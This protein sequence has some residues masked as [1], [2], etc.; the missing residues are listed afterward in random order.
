MAL[1]VKMKYAWIVRLYNI[2]A[3]ILT[4]HWG[5]EVK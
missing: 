5:Q 4:L 2:R 1:V 3:A